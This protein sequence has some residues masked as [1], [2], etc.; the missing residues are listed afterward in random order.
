NTEIAFA[1]VEDL[2]AGLVDPSADTGLD[3]ATQALIGQ[4]WIYAKKMLESGDSSLFDRMR[5]RANDIAHREATKAGRVL[6]ARSWVTTFLDETVQKVT[7][8]KRKVV[9]D[10]V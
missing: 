1:V 9:D 2:E 6:N 4:A 5:L 8:G 3:G 7:Q 10:L